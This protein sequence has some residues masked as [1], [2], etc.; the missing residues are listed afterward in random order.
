MARPPDLFLL[1]MNLPDMNGFDLL[2][3]LR[4]HDCLKHVPAVM[5]T[6]TAGAEHADAARA[7]GFVGYWTKPLDVDQTLNKIDEWLA[8]VHRGRSSEQRP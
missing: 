4:A 7:R 1:D 6:A 5:V 8:E 3:A 2:T